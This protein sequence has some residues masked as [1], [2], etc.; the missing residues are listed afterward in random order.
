M[1]DSFVISNTGNKIADAKSGL[2]GF[3]F[4]ENIDERLNKMPKKKDGIFIGTEITFEYDT[5]ERY[6]LL[7]AS[8]NSDYTVNTVKTVNGVPLNELSY[9][10]TQTRN[11]AYLAYLEKVFDSLDASYDYSV[12]SAPSQVSLNNYYPSP[13]LL[14]REFPD[15]LDSI[16]MRLV[17]TGKG[18]EV[19]ASGFDTLSSPLPSPCIL[20]RY[21]ELN[22]EI[23]TVGSHSEKGRN[24]KKSYDMLSSCGFKYVSVF[25]DGK[26]EMVNL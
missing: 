18:L 8:L 9:Y 17:F 2:T 5:H 10:T 16:L 20:K 23:I 11:S 6:A 22:G 19:N 25:K 13:L 12:I 7:S 4:V 15:I 26:C 3:C 14:Y 21:K 24:I 1:F